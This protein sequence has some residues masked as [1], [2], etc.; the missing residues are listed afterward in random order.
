MYVKAAHTEVQR[1][2]IIILGLIPEYYII[3][4]DCFALLRW[5]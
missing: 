5:W 2:S 4:F 1:M 3:N